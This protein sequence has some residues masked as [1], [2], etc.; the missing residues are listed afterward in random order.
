MVRV[1]GGRIV[2]EFHTL[3]RPPDKNVIFT[4]LHGLT[5]N[6][7]RKE[8]DFPEAAYAKVV[9][10][11]EASEFFVAHYAEFDKKV[12]EHTCRY[13][14]LAP[15]SLPWRCTCNASRGHFRDTLYNHKLPTVCEA[16][17][18]ELM[19]HHDAMA[20]ARA[21]AELAIRFL[22]RGALQKANV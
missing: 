20:D 17:G 9:E 10:L 14:E 11:A 4:E 16:L 6:R 22:E 2:E 15:P 19:S 5:W 21:C 12:L 1:V 13:Y 8:R 18:V 3:I 7:L